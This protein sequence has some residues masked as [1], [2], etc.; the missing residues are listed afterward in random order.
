MN[1]FRKI[2]DQQSGY[3]ECMMHAISSRVPD[4]DNEI[5]STVTNDNNSTMATTVI[6]NTPSFNK[7]RINMDQNQQQQ[8][9]QNSETIYLLKAMLGRLD[10]I[11]E[12]ENSAY[13]GSFRGATAHGELSFQHS[14]CKIQYEWREVALVLDRFFL[15]LFILLTITMVIC[16][17]IFSQI[18]H[19]YSS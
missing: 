2:T 12:R 16:I 18:G 10:Q 15:V 11:V 3:T 4:H 17:V 8:H 5:Q 6:N 1:R 13:Q 14:R 9:Q 19:G 7:N